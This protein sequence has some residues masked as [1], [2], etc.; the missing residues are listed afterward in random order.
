MVVSQYSKGSLG[1]GVVL[2]GSKPCPLKV[3]SLTCRVGPCVLV[4][5]IIMG[6]SGFG[7]P[8][9]EHPPLPPIMQRGDKARLD[10]AMFEPVTAMAASGVRDGLGQPTGMSAPQAID[11]STRGGVSLSSTPG[12][13]CASPLSLGAVGPISHSRS[14]GIGYGY[15]RG[16]GA[17]ISLRCR[18][19]LPGVKDRRRE[20][21]GDCQPRG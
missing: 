21:R 6:P 8:K 7:P 16:W 19:A 20:C 2:L 12:S 17:V 15:G 4:P 14:G 11:V 13:D 1:R 9:C 18:L 3:P 5:G 10:A